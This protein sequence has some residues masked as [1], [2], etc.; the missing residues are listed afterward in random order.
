MRRIISLIILFWM[1]CIVAVL[2]ASSPTWAGRCH[3][4]LVSRVLDV[5]KTKQRTFDTHTWVHLTDTDVGDNRLSPDGR[6]RYE[7]EQVSETH[8]ELFIVSR[9]T[10][11]RQMLMQTS[12]FF[13]AYWSADSEALL[14]WEYD[15]DLSVRRITSIV[16]RTGEL[17]FVH[18]FPPT[19]A[20]PSRTEYHRYL[21]T[22]YPLPDTSDGRGLIFIN[23]I[24]GDVTRFSESVLGIYGWSDDERWLTAATEDGFYII[25][26]QTGQTHSHFSNIV[27]GY[28]PRWVNGN[29]WFTH[30]DNY[31]PMIW[32][33]NLDDGTI[34]REI[35][36]A[37]LYSVSPNE[38]WVLMQYH[39]R[40]SDIDYALYHIP[41]EQM[42]PLQLQSHIYISESIFSPNSACLAIRTLQ[43]Q[44]ISR[45]T[46]IDVQTLEEI[47]GVSILD[48]GLITRTW[49]LTRE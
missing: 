20:A 11:Q 21:Y 41:T 17:R 36:N 15:D 27:E 14:V 18:E 8:N 47:N 38:A 33:A 7:S 6:Y 26:A 22:T 23:T 45:V 12:I 30:V 13:V 34:S 29:I 32:R 9:R 2:G 19:V 4:S 3:A 24:S 39:E 43:S 25:D 1:S 42:Y 49:W 10:N 31:R 28:N 16:H 46:I 40:S 44:L 35:D 48:N 5:A 37:T